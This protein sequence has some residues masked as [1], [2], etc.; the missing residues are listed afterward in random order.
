MV[1][2]ETEA[3]GLVQSHGGIVASRDPQFDGG[4]AG[5]ASPSHGGV[6]QL[7]GNASSSLCRRNPHRDQFDRAPS[8]IPMVCP[9]QPDDRSADDCQEGHTAL[10]GSTQHRSRLP[11]GIASVGL[12]CMAR[13]ERRRRV[14]QRRETHR[15][16]DG[17]LVGP[18]SSYD[19]FHPVSLVGAMVTSTLDFRWTQ[20]TQPRPPSPR[21]PDCM[22]LSVVVGSFATRFREITGETPG[23]FQRRWAT[24]GAPHI[25]GCFVFMWGLAERR[26]ADP[27]IEEK[28]PADRRA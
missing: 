27:A 4:R 17:T 3:R 9:D 15:L 19:G 16:E 2:R 25:P 21:T 8:G 5:L 11:V 20:S 23:A 18:N 28:L 12:R 24:T 14:G 1:P 7:G 6:H 22:W 10:P 26:S 13:S